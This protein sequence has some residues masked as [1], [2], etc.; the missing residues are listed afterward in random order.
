[1]SK[2]KHDLKRQLGFWLESMAQEE[3][4]KALEQSHSVKAFKEDVFYDE[5]TKKRKT[6]SEVNAVDEKRLSATE[7]AFH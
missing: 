1:M 3:L 5:I 7:R 2:E 4:A 6:A